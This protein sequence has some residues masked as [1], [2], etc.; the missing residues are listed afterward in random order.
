[1]A[2]NSP[3]YSEPKYQQ[4][5]QSFQS[6]SSSHQS[7]FQQQSNWQNQAQAVSYWRFVTK[8]KI[9]HPLFLFHPSGHS[10]L[11]FNMKM[12]NCISFSASLLG[13]T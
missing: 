11:G 2:S 10:Q 6:S 4:Y 12:N 3:W 5:W 1:M 9:N 13:R 7:P 8:V